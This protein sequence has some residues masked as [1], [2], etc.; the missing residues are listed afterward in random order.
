MHF[1]QLIN[2]P[3]HVGSLNFQYQDAALEIPR[4]PV[5]SVKVWF[6]YSHQNEIQNY[7]CNE[8][9]NRKCRADIGEENILLFGRHWLGCTEMQATVH[10]YLK[11]ANVTGEK[12]SFDGFAALIFS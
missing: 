6:S 1:V 7:H 8:Y 11:M 2:K 12:E 4:C 5:R 9:E 10:K 3:L